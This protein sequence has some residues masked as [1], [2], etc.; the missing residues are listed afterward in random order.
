MLVHVLGTLVRSNASEDNLDFPSERNLQAVFACAGV[1]EEEQQGNIYMEVVG[2]P[3]DLQDGHLHVLEDALVSLYQSATEE[4]CSGGYR[5]L[6]GAK[7]N[8]ASIPSS[9]QVRTF[10]I[11]FQ[12]TGRCKGCSS[13]LNF[14]SS[15]R[16]A[17]RIRP[18]GVE[19]VNVRRRMSSKKKSKKT[20]IYYGSTTTVDMGSTGTTGNCLCPPPSDYGLEGAF[21]QII[22]DIL[23]L[24]N[25]YED[26]GQVDHSPG[27]PDDGAGDGFGGAFSSLA[28]EDETD[29]PTQSPTVN[30]GSPTTTPAVPP[31]DAPAVIPTD[32]PAPDASAQPSVGQSGPT[33]PPVSAPTV[34]PGQTPVPTPAN[35][36]VAPTISPAETSSNP[37]TLSSSKPTTLSSS[38]PTAIKNVPTASFAP[39]AIIN[40]PSSTPS[41]A[42]SLRTSSSPTIISPIP[43]ALPSSSPSLQPSPNPTPAPTPA[44]NTFCDANNSP[45]TFRSANCDQGSQAGFQICM[46]FLNMPCEDVPLFQA[47]VEF[48]EGAITNDLDDHVVPLQFL[49][50]PGFCGPG[51]N[52]PSPAD[53]L[54]ICGQYEDIDG[55]SG[56]L[57][58]GTSV[59][60]GSGIAKPILWGILRLDSS[61]QTRLQNDPQLYSDVIIHEIGKC[62]QEKKKVNGHFLNHRSLNLFVSGFDAL[63]HVLGIGNNWRLANEPLVN[64]NCEYTGP[65]ATAVYRE[66]S[67]CTTGFPLAE[68]TNGHWS[69]DCFDAEIL[70]PQRNAGGVLIS[71][72]TIASLDD[73]GYTTDRGA[74][75]YDFISFDI[76]ETCRCTTGNLRSGGGLLWQWDNPT[77]RRWNTPSPELLEL[78]KTHSP[79]VSPRSSS[80]SIIDDTSSNITIGTSTT[81]LFW[82]EEGDT[83]FEVSV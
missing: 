78:A 72:M 41:S 39:T 40:E 37:T 82:N 19:A 48:W 43:T 53:D 4:V 21:H 18:R 67:G 57:G 11:D 44:T 59:N 68:C 61:D 70:T 81:V 71:E 32:S 79:P 47:A 15:G 45:I 74:V 33:V 5:H 24:R 3:S 36:S 51:F 73:M 22:D 27:L 75:E 65:A 55:S 60:D 64:D 49:N 29:E 17:S 80:S 1:D 77:Q 13:D 56:V 62:K 6:T 7:I 30:A 16:R 2:R 50:D 76:A 66:L 26:S 28:S 12:V 25:I 46:E 31:T 83:F 23:D 14:F 69:E 38:A 58:T 54:Y 9:N 10:V 52:P 20:S 34:N 35:E 63:G 8:T 42:P